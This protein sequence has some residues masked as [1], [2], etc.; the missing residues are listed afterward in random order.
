MNN[1]D[2]TEKRNINIGFKVVYL[3]WIFMLAA[4][5]IYV[6]IA[7]IIGEEAAVTGGDTDEVFNIVKYVLYI[8]GFLLLGAVY[9]I[10]KA[11]SNPQ[12]L[13]SR[14]IVY[15]FLI[16]LPLFLTSGGSPMASP[17]LRYTSGI[18]A[19]VALCQAVG[20]YGLIIFVFNG[21]F[22]SLYS[23]VGIAVVAQVYT[24]PRKDE[25]IDLAV[26]MKQDS[27]SQGAPVKMSP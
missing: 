12:S 16:S 17:V 23:M 9:F 26:R 18:M 3:I 7:N 4:L 22:I 27:I 21:D 1:L 24:R 13:T 8:I 19:C 5:F 2:E 25:F 6:V 20:F 10:R 14:I 15:S 11:I